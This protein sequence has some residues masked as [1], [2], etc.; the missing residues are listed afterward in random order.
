MLTGST[1][2]FSNA[3]VVAVT[4][5]V[6]IDSTNLSK[7]FR[8]KKRGKVHAVSKISLRVRPGQIYGLLGANGAGKTTMLRMLATLLKPTSGT[9]IVAGN[10][11]VQLQRR[12]GPKWVFWRRARRCMAD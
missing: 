6:M 1:K 8:D 4:I 9:A 11:V 5:R 3:N 10:D 2:T 7:S 12:C